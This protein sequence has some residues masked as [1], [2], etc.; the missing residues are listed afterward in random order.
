M[1]IEVTPQFEK[2]YTKL[3]E[4]IKRRAEKQIDYFISDHLH[5]SL[6]IE[7]LSPKN[8]QLWSLRIDKKYRIVFQYQS[9]QSV[10]FVAVGEHVWIYKFTNRL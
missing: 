9:S 5:P 4:S 8:K 6:N 10:V 2:L 1:T 3:P 7:K